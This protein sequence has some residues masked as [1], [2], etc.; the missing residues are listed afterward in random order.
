MITDGPYNGFL[1]RFTH[2]WFTIAEPIE[3]KMITGPEHF[4]MDKVQKVQNG[5]AGLESPARHRIMH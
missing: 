1:A 4:T 2:Q 3:A 5:L